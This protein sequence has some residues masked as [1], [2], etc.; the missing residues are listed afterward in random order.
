MRSRN[1]IFHIG[2][3][4][5]HTEVAEKSNTVLGNFCRPGAGSL[6]PKEFG[7]MR[8]YGLFWLE[9]SKGSSIDETTDM[10]H[11]VSM[12]PPVVLLR[13]SVL[14]LLLL[15]AGARG[16]PGATITLSPVADTTLSQ[17]SPANN[18]GGETVLSSGST[19]DALANRALLKFDIANFMPS[20]ATIQKVTLT[21]TV[22]HST[23]LQASSFSLHRV[24]QG[25]G[26]GTK[27]GGGAGA[28][29]TTGEATW[30]ARFY[31]APLWSASGGAAP[32][33]YV[34]APSSTQLVSGETN[35]VFGSTSNLA[36]NVQSWLTNASSNFGW[37]LISDDEGNFSTSQQFASREDSSNGPILII[38]Y[39]VPPRPHVAL[40]PQADTSL[41]ENSPTN[42]LGTASLVS[43]ARGIN[44]L[45]KR[46]RAL[47][48]FSTDAF[49]INAVLTS[50][51]L[52]LTVYRIPEDGGAR[53]PIFDL[54]RLLRPWQEGNKGTYVDTGS[55]GSPADP[56]E[57]TWNTR[58]FPSVLWSAPGAAAP[59]D[60]S[61]VVSSK[62][63]IPGYGVY[64]FTNLLPDVLYWQA[65]PDQN[66]GWI[67]I[68][69]DE[70]TDHTA[71]RFSS[72]EDANPTNAPTL[73]I[74]YIPFPKI[75][76]SELSGNR[77]NLYFVAEAGLAS[78]VQYRDSLSSGNWITLTNLPA[79]LVTRTNVVA[80]AY[81]GSQRFY[82][83]GVQ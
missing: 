30:D 67:L 4:S 36:A 66:Y 63:V 39:T 26:E 61:P 43:G 17:A 51:T 40:Y 72:R 81:T 68:C 54:H 49:P 56:G 65:H 25:W 82:R 3:C 73:V 1:V 57:T 11:I 71:R 10:E 46:T 23:A 78:V 19:D 59:L 70:V 55:N 45:Y 69:E 37:I 41:F 38:D 20:N 42:N 8:P 52:N 22:T 21:L 5:D 18:F 32:G 75:Y 13:H 64:G 77:F 48:Q 74:E 60:F 31:P 16:L 6:S 14:A 7:E 62:T 83:V 24:L 15:A 53:N 76:R 44:G 9:S 80:A 79:T 28:P 47:M 27:A 12:F 29:A 35:Y 2:Y 34:A 33:D 58:F 50:A